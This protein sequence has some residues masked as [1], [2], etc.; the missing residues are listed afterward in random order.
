MKKISAIV[1]FIAII[2]AFN[3]NS[4]AQKKGKPFAGKIIFSMTY[5]GVE[6]SQAAQMPTTQTT[7]ILGNKQKTT[8]DYGQAAQIVIADGDVE[9]MMIYI[10]I[11]G[12]KFLIKQSKTQ[13]DSIRNAQP[14]PII[15][16]SD[17]TKEIAGYKCKKAVIAYKDAETGEESQNIVW[18][19]EDLN[20]GEKINFT[21]EAEG[22][23][24]FAL[25]TE[26]KNGK[27]TIKSVAKE[28]K[29]E[30]VS[31][32]EF[33]QPA[34]AKELTGEEFRKMFGGGGDEE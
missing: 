4:Y 34:D 7:L 20:V 22:I 3:N 33:L 12:Q 15:T 32:I 23:K 21:G 10:D 9:T 30:K 17:E 18:Y 14:K 28:I 5:E 27:I 31:D 26:V 24:G 13:I 2:F 29:K 6:A 1:L 16:Y 19:T 11:M 25:A 8:V